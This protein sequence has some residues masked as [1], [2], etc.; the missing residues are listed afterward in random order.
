MPR[1]LHRALALLAAAALAA[2][3]D[4]WWQPTADVA[5]FQREMAGF[6][7]LGA[8]TVGAGLFL[9]TLAV[10]RLRGME[11]GVGAAA[12]L[13]LGV[14]LAP[15]LSG[16]LAG[17][18]LL[19]PA[20]AVA[21]LGLLA[22]A[23]QA[24]ARLLPLPVAAVLTL[25]G[26]GLILSA[27][28]LPPSSATLSPATYDPAADPRPLP[29]AGPDVVLVS[30]DTLRADAILGTPSSEGGNAAPTPYLDGLRERA[31]WADYALSPSNQ[32][33]PG[34]V[35]MLTGVDAMVHGV[36]SNVDF[37][38][39]ELKLLSEVF[40]DAGYA[41]AGTIA[42][43]LLSAATG[44]AR[45]Y[46]L[47][48]DQPIA[49]A[50]YGLMLTENL[51]RS[52]WVGAFLPTDTT[53][54]LFQR[55]FFKKAM[56]V[57]DIPIAERVLDAALPQIRLLASAERPYFAFV[58]FMDPHTAYRPPADL[59]GS[60]SAELEDQVA[61]RFMPPPGREIGL[62]LVREV[63]HALLAGED[64]AELAA[65]YYHLVYLEEVVMVDRALAKLE[66]ELEATG[67]DYVLLI[68]SDHGEQFGEY[69]LM[70]HAN[71]MYEENL[72]VPFVLAGPRVVP[73]RVPAPP[74]L[75]D[76]APTLLWHAGLPIP[77]VMTGTQVDLA[78][79][80]RASVQVD[81]KE[82]AVRDEA[83]LKWTGAWS[84]G[85]DD[86]E[87]RRLVDLGASEDESLDLLAEGT[88][89]PL[90]TLI[91]RMLEADTWAVRQAGITLNAAQAAMLSQLGY[92]DQ[93]DQR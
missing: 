45:G 91:Q 71:S 69:G 11:D 14:G 58:H 40:H 44:M 75:S 32:T 50:T 66:A 9:L 15:M 19:L 18:L 93:E 49:L 34:H 79:P 84:E 2:A 53:R 68:T 29:P 59:R 28:A 54:R 76:V 27:P 80:A 82:I 22:P 10:P 23:R 92:A 8:W 39:P 7:V 17:P 88:P 25:G 64:G 43:A 73:G 67:R 33:L 38:D 83:G 74:L 36:R 57:K 5:F 6:A 46:D 90:L 1:A 35:G 24:L 47:F 60:L 86:P 63:E 65:R 72:R 12:W 3:I 55:W 4:G 48:S 70:E 51:D 87:P 31:L 41:T 42:N 20:L 21:A 62:D 89:G 26:L 52:T 37:P 85:G 78:L 77:E 61:A 13:G 56:A 30:V 16:F 81:Q